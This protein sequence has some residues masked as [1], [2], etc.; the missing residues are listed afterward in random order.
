[1]TGAANLYRQEN[2]EYWTNVY[3]VAASTTS[4]DIFGDISGI[5]EVIPPFSGSWTDA[6]S[7][8][9]TMDS[10]STSHYYD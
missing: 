7:C 1:M 5:V 9:F 2:N 8:S 3:D 10:A 6:I 4:T